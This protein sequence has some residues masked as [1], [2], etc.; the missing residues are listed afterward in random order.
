ML[1]G[2]NPLLNFLAGSCANASGADKV[3]ETI[4]S[5][6]AYHTI[7][8]SD[9][10]NEVHNALDKFHRGNLDKPTVSGPSGFYAPLKSALG[11]RGGPKSAAR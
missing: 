8:S 11:S 9:T 3:Y 6:C 10:L 7:W 5:G 1:L 2:S 4:Q